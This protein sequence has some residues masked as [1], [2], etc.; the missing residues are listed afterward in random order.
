MRR[1][2]SYEVGLAWEADPFTLFSHSLVDAWPTFHCE[3][4]FDPLSFLSNDP[5]ESHQ[6]A[7]MELFLCSGGGDLKG[8]EPGGFR[9][10]LRGRQRVLHPL[11]RARGGS[12]VSPGVEFRY[13]ASG[14]NLSERDAPLFNTG[15][16]LTGVGF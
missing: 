1:K 12:R 16:T 8:W 4:Y 7:T 10:P 5:R 13:V 11:C 14:G 6:R 9:P 2:A 15:V 3:F